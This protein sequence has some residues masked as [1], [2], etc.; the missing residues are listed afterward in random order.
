M[1]SAAL[2]FHSF[3]QPARVDAE[4]GRV[5]RVDEQSAARS[6]RASSPLRFLRSVM[7]CPTPTTPTMLPSDVRRVVALSSTS[8]RRRPWCRAGTRSWPSRAQ[9]RVVQHLLDR[10]LELV[11]DEVLHQVAPITSLLLKPVIWA[12]LRFHSFTSPFASMPKMG[13]FAVSMKRLQLLRHARHL[14]LRL[15]ALRDVLPDAHHADDVAARVPP[16]GRIQQHLHAP[17]SLVKSG[18]LEVGRLAAQ[19]RVVE[20]LLHRRAV[21]LRDVR[22]RPGACPITS[23]LRV[24]RDLRCLAVP[25]VHQPVR[26]DAEDGRVRRVDEVVSSLATRVQLLLAAIQLCDVLPDTDHT[27]HGPADV[28]PG[29]GVQQHLDAPAVLR[30][31]R[32]LEVGRLLALKRVLKHLLHRVLVLCSDELRTR[33]WPITSSLR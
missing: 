22:R 8:T 24:A 16:R 31:E 19:Q 10:R 28:A 33:F 32:E 3:T 2:L 27:H 30:E 26:V 12:A 18:K 15:L 1:I 6:P 5:R 7:S 9:Q 4:D 13:A 14:Q 23:S 17:P 29:R 20:H 21:L 11:R 25:L